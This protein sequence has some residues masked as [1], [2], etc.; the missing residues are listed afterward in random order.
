MAKEEQRLRSSIVARTLAAQGH[1][2]LI[3]E[4]REL[5]RAVPGQF[6]HVLTPGMLRRP[7]SFSRIDPE[8]NR[9]GLLFQV[10][11]SG[12]AWLA[13]RQTNDVLDVL[14]PLGHGFPAPDPVRPW[15]LVGG[16]V[17]VP[18]LFA[19]T[20]MWLQHTIS[21][22]QVIIGARTGAWVVM[23]NDF[24]RLGVPLTVTTDDGSQGQPGN[25]LAPLQTWLDAHREGQ[26]YA[27]GPVPM[28]QAIR[29]LALG[30]ATAY[31]A[32]EQRMGCGIGACLA[33][34]VPTV[35]NSG[36]SYR[37]VCTDGPVFKAEELMW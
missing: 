23:E 30:R 29:R 19:A 32:L 34:V 31:L 27:C 7:L 2:E 5:S 6:A 25:V 33:C 20:Q 36:M 18:P 11:G 15:V 4:S 13:E 37:R 17:G 14:G 3:L 24:K 22:P 21:T 12:T 1:V 10:V 9:V 26:V 16:G 8:H 35:G 28:L